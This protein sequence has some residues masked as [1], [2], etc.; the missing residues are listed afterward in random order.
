MTEATVRQLRYES[1]RASETIRDLQ[2]VQTDLCRWAG[3]DYSRGP[4]VDA[5]RYDAPNVRGFFDVRFGWLPVITINTQC[6]ALVTVRDCARV[7]AHEIVHWRLW[8]LNHPYDHNDVFWAA[9]D[10][11]FFHTGPDT[12]R[13]EWHEKVFPMFEKWAETPLVP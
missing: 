10:R 11:M 4:V 7:I 13:S 6:P 8:S 1:A 2:M 12:F 5:A 3:L 9:A